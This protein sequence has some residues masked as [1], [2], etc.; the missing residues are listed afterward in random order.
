MS[1]RRK[2]LTLIGIA[3]SLAGLASI[4]G[5][6]ALTQANLTVSNSAPDSYPVS[7][8]TGKPGDS[9]N[10]VPTHE[11]YKYESIKLTAN[12]EHKPAPA[13]WVPCKLDYYDY[14]FTFYLPKEAECTVSKAGSWREGVALMPTKTAAGKDTKFE[15]SIMLDDP[16]TVVRQDFGLA[17]VTGGALQ[18]ED[19]RVNGIASKQ[20]IDIGAEGG[21]FR[22]V[23][24]PIDS[25][26]V[27][28]FNY[29]VREFS[30]EEKISLSRELTNP[31]L[32]KVINSFSYEK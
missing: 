29:Q 8:M 11:D 1:K 2:L 25:K 31:I 26:V 7:Y 17:H 4:I 32:D 19:I 30:G 20:Y 16:A 5:L 21:L 22:M 3:L 12:S 23:M 13:G 6:I 10:E 24:I 18:V 28:V 15:L 14:Q 9:A 27:L